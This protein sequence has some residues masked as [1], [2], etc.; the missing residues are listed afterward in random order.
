[1]ANAQSKI[2]WLIAHC[3]LQKEKLN[4]M[5]TICL[6][7][8]PHIKLITFKEICPKKSWDY[9]EFKI[10]STT[11]VNL[12]MMMKNKFLLTIKD[13]VNVFDHINKFHELISRL[14]KT[15][16]NIKVEE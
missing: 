7:L 16:D 3:A 5:N 13:E 8:G 4:D 15:N 10:A 12:L 2:I 11:L 1:M 6:T 14:M 9:L